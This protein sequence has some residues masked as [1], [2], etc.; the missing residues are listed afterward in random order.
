MT[1]VLLIGS[2]GQLG[3]E[4]ATLLAGPSLTAVGHGELEV[5]DAAAT[6]ALL[7]RVR[8]AVIL[9]TSAF[10]AVD[11][12]EDE[13]ERAFAVNA[14]A[15]RH[16]AQRASEHGSLLVHFSTDYVFAGDAQRPYREEDLPLPRSAYAT[17]KLAGECF[18]RA[19]ATRHLVVRSAGLFGGAGSAGKGGNFVSAILRRARAGETLRVVA[20]QVTAPTYARDLAVTVAALVEHAVAD[21]TIATGVVHATAAGACSW[22]EF[23]AAIVADAGLGVAVT[24]ISTA[25]LGARA[26]S[27]AYSVLENARLAALGIPR[28]AP[29]RDGLRRYLAEC[30]AL[31]SSR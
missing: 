14:L 23:A 19:L 5:T 27:P 16:L 18:V 9:N 29:W 20:D 11:R 26:A 15:V 13:A 7:A 28:P 3:R 10:H 31:A 25:E 17:S 12:C 4:L 30:G 6:D 21:P 2:T 22:H 1:R 8:P 24:P